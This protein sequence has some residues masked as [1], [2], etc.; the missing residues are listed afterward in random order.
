MF[1]LRSETGKENPG[2]NPSGNTHLRTDTG[3]I[4]ALGDAS[5]TVH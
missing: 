1:L 3:V 2:I 4:P 5:V